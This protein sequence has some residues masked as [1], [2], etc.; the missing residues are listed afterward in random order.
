[1]FVRGVFLT[2]V[3]F[4]GH[5]MAGPK[6]S[7]LSI[8]QINKIV[9]AA[10]RGDTHEMSTI[11]QWFKDLTDAQAVYCPRFSKHFLGEYFVG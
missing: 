6:I 4:F 3:L 9:K 11:T 5:V 2:F 10:N 1:M 7:E 8:E